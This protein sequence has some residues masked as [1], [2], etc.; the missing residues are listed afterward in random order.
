[1]PTIEEIQKK[2]ADRKA[3]LADQELAQRALDLEA[4]DALEVQH[5]DSNIDVVDVA[6]TPGLPTCF[7]VR[8]PTDPEMRRYKSRLKGI[9]NS[10]DVDA[11][12]AAEELGESC[13]VYPAADVREQMKAARSGA[14]SICGT[15]ALKL[16][17]GRLSSE[18]KG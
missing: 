3:A 13:L 7:A 12:A 11:I 16:C 2:R 14:L 5:G 17:Q 15:A 10:K 9:A 4:V 18:G 1:M 6:Y 8:V